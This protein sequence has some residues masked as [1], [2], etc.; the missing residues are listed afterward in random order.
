MPAPVVSFVALGPGDSA[1][2]TERA[3]Q[4]LAEADVVVGPGEAVDADRLIE[5]ARAGKRVV[6][7]IAGEALESTE[8]LALAR[9]VA[10]AGV[11]IEVV[12]G[13][14]AR[15]AAAAFAGVIGRAVR[16]DARDVEAA[17]D[18]EE[19]EAPVTL[20]AGAGTP[21]QRVVVTTAARAAQDA[22]SL[23][24]Q[25]ELVVA[26]GAPDEALRWFERRP[27]FGKRILVTRAREQAGSTA[28][29]LRE[30]GAEPLVV[31]T[32]EIHPPGDTGPLARAI[33]DLRAGRYA[34]VAFTSANGV[35]RTWE[36]L[37]AAGGDARAFGAARLAAIGPATARAL[38]RRGL[39]ADVVAKEF[40][41]EG[42]AAK[43]LEGLRQSTPAAGQ[44][45]PPQSPRVLLA[46][47]AQARDALPRALREAGCQVDVV[48]AYETHPPSPD[49][50]SALER[51]LEGGRVDVVTFTSSSTVDN[52]CDWL[53]S[54][55]STLL[56]AARI[57]CIGPVTA[58]TARAR[59]LRVDVLAAEYTVPGLVRALRTAL[60]QE[61]GAGG[62]RS[63][64]PGAGS[65]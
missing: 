17:V 47:A 38:E 44:A 25:G 28:A 2:R 48:P 45:S 52:L 60:A 6:R 8:G 11:P 15:A 56:A 46:R 26:F 1:L 63:L 36:A 7:A 34:W 64:E 54:R 35:D 53:G 14:G 55:A 50:R 51:E 42:L 37:R 5:L 32:I 30:E 9:A 57:A 16:V 18:G 29:L 12:P 33:A 10:R 31:P 59:G 58:E 61:Q 3:A 49:A 19:R 23:G 65:L 27:L 41:G 20:V 39:V 62:R 21:S 24:G 13:V 22:R 43:M 40:R 4:R